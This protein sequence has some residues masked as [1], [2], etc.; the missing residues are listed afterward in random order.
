M[1]GKQKTIEYK[2]SNISPSVECYII[3]VIRFREN[4]ISQNEVKFAKGKMQ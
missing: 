2:S 1:S 4:K 3:I